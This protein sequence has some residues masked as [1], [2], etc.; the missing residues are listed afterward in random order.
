MFS[1][2]GGRIE[3]ARGL[4]PRA[5]VSVGLLHTYTVGTAITAVATGGQRL[6]IAGRCRRGA[7]GCRA[8][9]S[10]S[11]IAATG[12]GASARCGTSTRCAAAVVGR[13]IQSSCGRTD[14]NG[15]RPLLHLSAV[16]AL[17]LQV[18]GLLALVTCLRTRCR[19]TADGYSSQRRSE[20]GRKNRLFLHHAY[21]G[22]RVMT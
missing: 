19:A 4:F 15:S 8:S 21:N 7:D 5:F 13:H 17:H 11:R 12:S 9:S 3:K 6:V 14:V 16:S 20:D 22:L 2:C 10:G 18:V 1:R